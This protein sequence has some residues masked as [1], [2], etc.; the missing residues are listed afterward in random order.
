MLCYAR[1]Q[2]LAVWAL[3][4]CS[5]RARNHQN[6]QRVLCRSMVSGAR[7]RHIQCYRLQESLRQNSTVDCRN[8]SMARARDLSNAGSSRP[9]NG[10]VFAPRNW[11]GDLPDDEKNIKNL[12]KSGLVF[13]PRNWA[14]FRAQKMGRISR[15]ENGQDF[16]PRKWTGF[17]AQKT[18]GN[19]KHTRRITMRKKPPARPTTEKWTGS[20]AQD[21]S[22]GGPAR[23]WARKPAQNLGLI[24]CPKSGGLRPY[25]GAPLAQNLGVG[26]GPEMEGS[27]NASGRHFVAHRAR[28]CRQPERQMCELERVRFKH[29]RAPLPCS[30]ARRI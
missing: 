17:R 20:P 2:C 14:G 24:S 1:C 7:I 12:K 30:A 5:K 6:G 11:A 28:L 19:P 15:P 16:A 26:L 10:H 9:E 13:A 18:A 8:G 27:T 25:I 3:R 21:S 23:N 29:D 22:Q 4:N